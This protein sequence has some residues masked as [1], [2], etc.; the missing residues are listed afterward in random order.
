MN[1]S[2]IF[3]HAGRKLNSPCNLGWRLESFEKDVK[4]K[5]DSQKAKG[6]GKPLFCLIQFSQWRI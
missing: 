4:E 3:E 1:V 6:F 2:G 5:H